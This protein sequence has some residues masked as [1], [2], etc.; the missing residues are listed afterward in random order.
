M[1][2][3]QSLV[4]DSMLSTLATAVQG[5]GR[6]L[7]NYFVARFA[8]PSALGA[9]GASLSLASFAS[10][11]WPSSAGSAATKFIAREEVAHGPAVAAAVERHLAKRT[12]GCLALLA[13]ACVALA[14]WVL[15]LS[16]PAALVAGL[17]A[18]AFSLYNFTRGVQY[19]RAQVRQATWLEAGASLLALA[20][21][22][23]VLLTDLSALYAL[24]LAAGY[25]LYG[26]VSWPWRARSAPLPP[27]LRREIDT[28]VGWAVVGILASTGLL[29]L[30]MLVAKTVGTEVEAGMYA[31]A[32]AL[33]TPIS[34]LARSFSL[35]LFPS[36]ARRVGAGD[37][38]G[39]RR[40]TTSATQGL[41]VSLTP[42]M[43]LLAIAAEPVL[44]FMY[45]A[46]YA[47]AAPLL[48]ILVL[49]TLLNT[50]TVAIVNALTSATAR[51][52][53]DSA[54]LALIGT[55]LGLVS[56]AILTP[57]LGITGVAWSY[58]LGSS[59]IAIAN[60]AVVWRRQRQNW[61]AMYVR[62]ALTVAAIAAAVLA[63]QTWRGTWVVPGALAGFLTA[64]G[65]IEHRAIAQ[66][67][68]RRARAH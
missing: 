33:A 44:T 28:F 64:W 15:D 5:L 49:S 58:L 59:A 50:A 2:K 32:L 3:S 47:A 26:L 31:A 63:V 65:L 39:L 24:P 36:M 61:T 40:Q 13:P 7:T 4:K 27:A 8:G 42:L 38:A 67:P 55:A 14:Y 68:R 46:R 43:G 34:M 19:G 17:L 9:L 20:L 53:R 51:G 62:L 52:I 21:L 1:T 12:L 37:T 57:L 56:L 23:L 6:F 29:Q 22:A 16:A 66:L 25:G 45:G 35:V 11:A 18:V 60:I 48:R 41:I 54:L 30:T 10:L